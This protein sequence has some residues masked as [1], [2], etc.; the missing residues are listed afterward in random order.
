MTSTTDHQTGLDVTSDVRD[1][2]A[3]VVGET[4]DQLAGHGAQLGDQ[5]ADFLQQHEPAEC[6]RR[7]RRCR[8]RRWPDRALWT[9]RP[10]W[11]QRRTTRSEA[12]FRT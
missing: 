10:R 3:K 8:D 7:T 4:R 9:G 12:W 1:Q 5:A 11:G 2:T 6:R